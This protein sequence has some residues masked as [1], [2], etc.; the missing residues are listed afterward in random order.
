[1]GIKAAILRFHTVNWRIHRDAGR[2]QRRRQKLTLFFCES[3]VIASH[4]V[5]IDHG[6]ENWDDC[7][8]RCA[9]LSLAGVIVVENIFNKQ[10][11]E[12]WGRGVREIEDGIDDGDHGRKKFRIVRKTRWCINK[13]NWWAWKRGILFETRTRIIEILHFAYLDWD[14][15]VCRR[16]FSLK[17]SPSRLQRGL[18]WFKYKFW[19]RPQTRLGCTKF[20]VR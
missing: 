1:M 3:V 7:G 18:E 16:P 4:T 9:L 12:G 11:V 2:R 15:V 20:L 10:A 17:T 13:F 5:K 19:F 8:R 14:K 6:T